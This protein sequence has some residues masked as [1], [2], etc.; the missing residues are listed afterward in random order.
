M[1]NIKSIFN[2]LTISLFLFVFAACES[3]W[4]DHTK[5]DNNIRGESL[6]QVISSNSETSVFASIL[7][8]TGYDQLLKDDKMLTVFAP[9]NSALTSV[10]MNDN[11]ALLN[12]VKN[13]IAYASYTVENGSFATSKIQMVNSKYTTVNG[14]QINGA[15]LDTEAGKY[16][17]S[18]ANGILHFMNG[19]ISTQKNIWEYLQAQPNNL[20]AEFI[21]SMDKLV[22]D[23]NKSVQI[24][25]DP[26]GRPLYDTVWINQ[27]L[28]LD[29]FPI[30]D[31]S[32]DLTFALLPNE[33]VTRI[34]AKYAKYFARPIQTEQDSLVRAQLIGDCVLAPV[35]INADGRYASIDGVLVD[36]STAKITETYTASNG[37]VYKLS[38][39][40]VKIYENKVKTIFIEAEDFNSIFTDNRDAWSKRAKTTMSGGYDILM[41]GFVTYVSKSIDNPLDSAVITSINGFEY[42]SLSSPDANNGYWVRS[43]NCYIQFNPTINSIAYKLY[44]SAYDDFLKHSD[45]TSIANLKNHEPI[46]FSQKMLLSLPDQPVVTRGADAK[47]TN[48]FSATS[49][50][51]SNRITAGVQEEKQLYRCLLSKVTADDG[52]FVLSKNYQYTSEDDFFNHFTGSDALGDKETIISPT[53]GKATVLVA[54]T[55]EYKGNY[56]GM[57][58]LDYIKLVPVVDPND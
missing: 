4:D 41:N 1:K 46:K 18:A 35:L 36:I 2:C 40:D 52:L 55:T 20:Q 6:M 48:N 33:V 49:A 26:S 27:N 34:E 12:L 50:F 30:N 17:I 9:V 21:H 5:I 54:N 37:L 57:L 14:L 24:G 15:S 42:Q 23:M 53:Y 31:E 45:G 28:L 51:A 22:M 10:D 47:I 39:A 32:Q 29:A 43:N 13:H 3:D 25:V 7:Q 44:W 11:D 58:F 16:N 19:V 8:K 56:A 38:D